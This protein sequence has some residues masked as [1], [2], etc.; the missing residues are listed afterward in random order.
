MKQEMMESGNEFKEFNFGGK[1]SGLVMILTGGIFLLGALGVTILGF[2]PWILMAFLPAFWIG[3]AAVNAYRREQRISGHI[4][5]MLL[6]SLM[7]LAYI[8]ASQL[9]LNTGAIWPFGLIGMG[10]II[11]F[12][13]K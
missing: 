6:Y 12:I 2:S 7:G 1:V 5:A 9:G 4:A 8:F 10:L 13:R 11:L 3:A